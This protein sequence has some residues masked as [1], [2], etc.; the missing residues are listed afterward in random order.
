MKFLELETSYGENVAI[1]IDTIST[2]E[3]HRKRKCGRVVKKVRKY[4]FFGPQVEKVEYKCKGYFKATGKCKITFNEKE[5]YYVAP[6]HTVERQKS[7]VYNHTK[8]EVLELL[9]ELSNE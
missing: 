2:I 7:R 4:W 5:K 3:D 8:E 6:G 9:K 1:N